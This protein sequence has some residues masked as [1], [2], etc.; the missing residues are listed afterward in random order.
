MQQIFAILVS[1]TIIPLTKKLPI[2]LRLILTALATSLL[3]GLPLSV[4]ADNFL[5]TVG[6]LSSLSIILVV[7]LV[8]VLGS[9]LQHYGVLE[10]LVENFGLLVREKRT[11]LMLLPAAFGLLVVPGGAMLSA[12]FVK[13]I[14]GEL[15]VPPARRA[16]LNLTFRHLAM[17][18]L[19][20]ATGILLVGS[21]LPAVPISRL[22]LCNLG[23]VLVMQSSDYLLYVRQVPRQP[24]PI[25]PHR[26]AAIRQLIC[27]LSPILLLLLLN[28]FCGISILPATLAALGLV[29]LRW[30]RK[31]PSDFFRTAAKAFSF[32]TFFMMIGVYFLQHT[33]QSLT[34]LLALCTNLLLTASGPLLLL[35]MAVGAGGL[36]FL[37]GMNLVP[38]GVFLPLLATMPISP[39]LQ[40]CYCFFLSIWSF[41]G[42]YFSPLHLCQLLTIREMGAETRDVYREYARLFPILAIASFVLF[43]F[44]RGI[45]GA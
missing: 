34:A 24:H 7:V 10:H 19:P 16:V 32:P 35:G 15:G 25:A 13:Q 39:S 9:L 14:G 40:L 45:L 38:M 37:T 33:V 29:F 23:F 8:G 28:G 6:S 42:Y 2:G 31:S 5:A 12:P 22:L 26:A 20:T 11:L 3:A 4:V 18:L 44:Y 27:D 43:S 1:F 30:G 21:L 17:F 41:L 36:G